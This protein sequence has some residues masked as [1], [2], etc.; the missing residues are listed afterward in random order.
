MKQA[1][2]LNIKN[3]EV[4]TVLFH[5]FKKLFELFNFLKIKMSEPK[6]IIYGS[7]GIRPV[8]GFKIALLGSTKKW[9]EIYLVPPSIIFSGKKFIFVQFISSIR[10]ILIDPPRNRSDQFQEFF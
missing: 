4:K 1:L 5:R 10:K 8:V 6:M 7:S 3:I 9:P 2:Y